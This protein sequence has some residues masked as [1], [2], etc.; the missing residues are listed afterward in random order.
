MLGGNLIFVLFVPMAVV[1]L[2]RAYAGGA[3][4][5]VTFRG[6]DAANA[7]QT[8]RRYG[9]AIKAYEAIE[10]RLPDHAGVLYNH[11]RALQR[12]AQVKEAVDVY[13]NA[14][15][16]CANFAPAARELLACYGQLGRTTEAAALKA[17]W[18]DPEEQPEGQPDSAP[19][20]DAGAPR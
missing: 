1:Q 5:S 16:A 8:A 12:S 19:L 11:G 2:I 6:L 18:E 9:G 20:S 13:R 3:A 10:H 7:S 15:A 4:R 14:L 17:L